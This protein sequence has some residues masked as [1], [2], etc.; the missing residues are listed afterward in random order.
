M[1]LGPFVGEGLVGVETLVWAGR[2]VGLYC[3]TG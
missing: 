1:D 3:S 2:G